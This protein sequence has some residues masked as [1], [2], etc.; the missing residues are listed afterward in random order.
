MLTLLIG[1]LALIVAL[2]VSGGNGNGGAQGLAHVL[3]VLRRG[4]AMDKLKALALL[5]RLGDMQVMPALV[6]ALRD[7]D[8]R[9]RA[10]AEAAMW[11]IWLQSGN[12]AVDALMAKGIHLL[13]RQRYRDAVEVFSEAIAM[14]PTFAEAYNKRA[15]V[16]Y[17]LREFEKSIADIHKTLEYNPVHFGALSGMGLCYLGLNEPRQA[18]TWFERALAVNPNLESIRSYVQQ[19]RASFEDQPG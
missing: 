18:L 16:Y 4:T 13:E 17:L 14:A 2:A 1:G 8:G 9:V 3:G 12:E 19:L 15:T 7:D 6:R 11:T 10:A 5:A